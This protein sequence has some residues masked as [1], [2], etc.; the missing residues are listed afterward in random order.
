M[1]N[2]KLIIK[3]QEKITF[4]NYQYFGKKLYREKIFINYR[5]GY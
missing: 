1:K 3:L 2:L 5:D 4:I